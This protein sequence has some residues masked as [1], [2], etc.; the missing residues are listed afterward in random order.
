MAA[1]LLVLTVIALAYANGTNDASKGV[2]TLVGAHLTSYP[3]ALAW[4]TLWAVTGGALSLFVGERLIRAFSTGL[5]VAPPVA[6]RAFLVSVAAGALAWVVT[7]PL[8]A[9]L[10]AAVRLSLTN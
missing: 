8:A 3:R 5:L 1:A 2:G 6:A 7:L 4:G 9:L 10:A